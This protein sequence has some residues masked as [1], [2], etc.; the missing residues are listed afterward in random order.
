MVRGLCGV[1]ASLRSPIMIERN[2][3]KQRL[4]REKTAACQSGNC[5]CFGS[6]SQKL[7]TKPTTYTAVPTIAAA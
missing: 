6:G 1:A 7:A 5:S 4:R 2:R 3:Q